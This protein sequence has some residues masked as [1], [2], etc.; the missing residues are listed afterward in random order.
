[1][2]ENLKGFNMR[3]FGQ[4]DLGEA[5]RTKRLVALAKELVARPGR[6]LPQ[7]LNQPSM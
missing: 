2:Q 6:S 3:N 4:A 7:K 1:M 5:R